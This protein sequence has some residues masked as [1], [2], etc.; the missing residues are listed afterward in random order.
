[1]NEKEK[2]KKCPKCGKEYTGYPAIS[3]TDNKTEICSECGTAEALAIFK[4]VTPLNIPPN[5]KNGKFS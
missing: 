4:A 1:M 2:V 5:L 3:R